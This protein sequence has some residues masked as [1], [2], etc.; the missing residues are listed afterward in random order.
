MAQPGST[1]SFTPMEDLPSPSSSVAAFEPED[2]HLR[3]F[4]LETRGLRGLSPKQLAIPSLGEIGDFTLAESTILPLLCSMTHAIAATLK[5]V[6]ELRLQ[7]SDLEAR[8]ANSVPDVTDHSTQLNQIQSSLRD[9]SHRVAHLPPAHAV[10]PPQTQSSRPRPSTVTAPQAPLSKGAPP[11]P[12]KAAT[13]TY[14]ATVGGTSNL[15]EAA[16]EILAARQNKKGKKNSP[17]STSATKVAEAVKKASPP[18]APTPLASAAR[19]SF[20]PRSSRELH[21]DAADIK[22]HVP[23]LAAAVLREANCSLPRSRKAVTNDR[24]SV[25]LIVVDSSVPAASYAP[26]FEALTTKLNQSF[27][28]GENPW[29]PFRLAPT[30]VQLAIHS[31]PI[32]YMPHQDEDLFNY[33]SDSILNSKDVTISAARFLTPNRQSRMEKRAYSVVVNVEPDSVQTMLPSIYLFGN[34]RTVERAY[35]SSPITQC[36]KCWK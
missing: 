5:A 9:L 28:V 10:P 20:A 23:D 36:Q 13:Q 4:L 11:H 15:D 26:Y 32:N 8:V 29:L 30:S 27:P 33:L 22:A 17:A 31:L 34:T 14:A 1:H 21:P 2:R 18:K 3:H 19:R 25:T 35:S 12:P 24:G 6:E 16:R 7:T